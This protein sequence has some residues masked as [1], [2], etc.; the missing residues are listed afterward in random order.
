MPATMHPKLNRKLA[1]GLAILG[2]TALAG[3]AYAAT[4]GSSTNPRQAFLD[5]VASRLHVTPAQLSSALKGASLDQLNAAVNAG[6]LTQAQA[7]A[8]EQRIQRGGSPPPFFRPLGRPSPHFFGAPSAAA[9]YLGVSESQ[10]ADELRSGSTLAQIARSRGKSVA[11]LEQA[12]T[13]SIRARLDKAVADGRVT[14]SQAQ[15]LLRALSSRL[16]DEINGT[17]PRF[18]GHRGSFFGHSDSRERGGGPAGIG[19]PPAAG[20]A[21]IGVP[22]VGGPAGIGV[23]PAAA[24][25]A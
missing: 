19:V 24:P 10:L 23:P 9:G 5:D 1:I 22:P 15:Q 4:Q 25:S 6:R 20:P 17:G 12:I 16:S 13:A 3:G 8:I 18:F 14:R 7:N 21:G 11:G 2:A